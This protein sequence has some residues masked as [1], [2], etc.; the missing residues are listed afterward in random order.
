[1]DKYE[2]II[3]KMEKYI[4]TLNKYLNNFKNK[5]IE[6][7]EYN[8]K[9]INV[10]KLIESINYNTEEI[11]NVLNRI[12]KELLEINQTLL[13]HIEITKINSKIYLV[14]DLNINGDYIESQAFAFL[15]IRSYLGLPI[16][17]PST[18]NCNEPTI[19]GTIIKK[20]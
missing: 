7:R 16:S 14:D 15:A 9:G 1:M 5:I 17:Y 6:L 10:D 18:T 20:F 4:K 3:K 11:Q 8:K 19:G 2:E 12:Y 13:N